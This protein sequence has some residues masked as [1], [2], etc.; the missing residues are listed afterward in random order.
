MHLTR[1]VLTAFLLAG[2]GACQ[3]PWARPSPTAGPA[4]VA[5]APTGSPTL[6]TATATPGPP[7]ATPT[8][9][10]AAMPTPWAGELPADTVALYA[11]GTWEAPRLYALAADGSSADLG[12]IVTPW[13]VAS[14]SGRWIADIQGL[15]PAGQVAA[16]D[17]RSGTTLT[18]PFGFEGVAGSGIADLG[19]F[20]RDE[21]RLAFIEVAPPSGG[22]CR[23]AYTVVSLQDGSSRRYELSRDKAQMG[24]GS[25]LGWSADGEL[26]VDTFHPYSEGAFMGVWALRLPAEGGLLPP[27]APARQALT[28]GA[29]RS[30]P[31]LS[32]D[33]TRLL[34]LVRNPPP[35]S[36]DDPLVNELWSVDVAGG[37][38][39]LLFAPA[40]GS[41][42]GWACAWS[43][44]GSQALFAQGDYT[45]HGFTSSTLR[46]RDAAGQVRDVGS[47]P[48]GYLNDLYWCRPD[49]ALAVM[50]QGGDMVELYLVDL[51]GRRATLAVSASYVSVLRCVR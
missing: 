26:L 2:L 35:Q 9:T 6:P 34:Y 47:L 40:Q 8:A 3:A 29:Y 36:F 1:L 31:R 23:W 25:P 11:A 13:S 45:A 20:D 12:R 17:L 37:Q 41:A 46:A 33:G 27:D 19:A 49:L 5:A 38:P 14:P 10:P 24:P 43:P 4:A 32:P 44:D 16:Y 21:T 48:G 39:T 15:V 51:A 42:L 50:Y 22:C 28:G 18:V 30:T 7:T